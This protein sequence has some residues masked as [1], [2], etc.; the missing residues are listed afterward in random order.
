MSVHPLL[1]CHCH[2][3][4][5]ALLFFIFRMRSSKPRA[6]S[7]F[8]SVSLIALGTVGISRIDPLHRIAHR[9][10]PRCLHPQNGSVLELR[11]ATLATLLAPHHFEMPHRQSAEV[12]VRDCKHYCTTMYTKTVVLC[13]IRYVLVQQRSS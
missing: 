13:V 4:T 8:L 12:I 5:Q 1:C 7:H 3:D 11:V 10:S 9:N 6:V 2:V